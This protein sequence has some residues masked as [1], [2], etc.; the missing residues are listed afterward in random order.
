VHF[1]QLHF[2]VGNLILEKMNAAKKF[3]AALNKINFQRQHTALK[4]RYQGEKIHQ[5]FNAEVKNLKEPSS[6]TLNF[7]CSKNRITT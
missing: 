4:G 7:I 2:G 6:E 3:I 1:S 5:E